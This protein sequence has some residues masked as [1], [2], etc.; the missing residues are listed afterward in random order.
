VSTY[1]A[2][3]S[4]IEA[5]KQAHIDLCREAESQGDGNLFSDYQLP[6]R[7]LPELNRATVSTETT[8]FSKKITQ[9]LIIASMTGGTQ[10]ATTIN[11]HLAEAAEAT[12][13]ALGVGS[14]RI[15][16]EQEDARESFA[17]VRRHA[18]NAFLFANMGVAQLNKGYGVSEFQRVID[19]IKADALYLHINPLQEALQPEGDTDFSGL[20]DKIGNL[21]QKIDIP[22]FVKEVGHGIDV[23][24]AQA[25]IER[26]VVGID[27]AGV[28]G[29]SYAWVEARRAH[30]Q[31]YEQ[32][33]KS[34][35]YRSDYLI[36][37][38]RNLPSNIKKVISGGVR[39]PIEVVK[40]GI[41]GADYYSMAVPFLEASLASTEAVIDIIKLYEE[42]LR[43]TLYICGCTSW[44]QVTSL[45]L[46]KRELGAAKVSMLA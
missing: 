16:L 11:M 36:E 6:Y 10:H 32:W 29:T 45:S 27:C 37:Q 22:V 15:G 20:L 31:L 33:F 46:Q 25:L 12:G 41:L 14:Q 42:G 18:P 38:Y 17:L 24:T 30:N 28:G 19:M 8:L 26:G 2:S 44:A 13:V 43:T 5:R 4:Q 34:V 3:M 1:N 21:V 9:P 23:A 7:A 40:A 39:S 35:G